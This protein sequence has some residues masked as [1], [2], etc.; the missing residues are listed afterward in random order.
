MLIHFRSDSINRSALALAALIRVSLSIDRREVYDHVSRIEPIFHLET[1]AG[2]LVCSHP[3]KMFFLLLVKLARAT[4]TANREAGDLLEEFFDPFHDRATL[5]L[6][7]LLRQASDLRRR[8]RRVL[9]LYKCVPPS[10]LSRLNIELC[11][12][13]IFRIYCS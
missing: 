2:S 4:L 10:L 5:Q 7:P 3:E 11:S 13:Q 9:D 6:T 8:L 1:L 12:L